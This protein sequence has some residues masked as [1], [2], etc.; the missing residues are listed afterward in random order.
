VIE[1]NSSTLYRYATINL[2]Q[3][4]HNLGDA[5]LAG[6]AAEAFVRSFVVSMP[7]GKQNTFA[8][9]TL[10]EV[11]AVQI[12]RRRP[13][14]LVGAF[15]CPVVPRDGQ[16]ISTVSAKKLADRATEVDAKYGTAPESSYVVAANA[17]VAEVLVGMGE[18][19]SLD[20]LATHVREH[21][22]HALQGDA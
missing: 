1:F 22:I 13:V 16:A 10:P 5:D 19:V 9:G 20:E 12:R 21:S 3:L 18:E 14:N 4:E 7:T 17:A 11:V 15:E 6:R 2:D 8:N